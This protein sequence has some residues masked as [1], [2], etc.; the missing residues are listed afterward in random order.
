MIIAKN[1]KVS[2]YYRTK[3]IK[4]K[5]REFD[6]GGKEGQFFADMGSDSGL[7]CLQPN[8]F[9]SRTGVLLLLQYLKK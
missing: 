9:N 6:A 4:I 8:I 3:S 1:H 7:P 5:C 2:P